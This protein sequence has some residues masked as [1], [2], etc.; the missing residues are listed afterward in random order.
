MSDVD[1]V[2]VLH[3]VFK[4]YDVN[5]TGYLDVS[6]FVNLISHLR[7]Y[8]PQLKNTKKDTITAIFALMDK[9]LDNKIDFN[10]FSKWWN[11]SKSCEMFAGENAAK[12]KKAYSLYQ[13][14]SSENKM[15]HEQFTDMLKELNLSYSYEDFYILDQ[16]SDGIMS[17][18]EFC[19]WLRW[20]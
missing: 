16:N 8:I 3:S 12:L 4:R 7:K 19:D 1:S 13:T 9:N 17:F 5:N 2:T 20:F 18:S 6:Q 14:N 10:E 15:T 11:N